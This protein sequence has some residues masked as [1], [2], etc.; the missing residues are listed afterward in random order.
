MTTG[1]MFQKRLK[2]IQITPKTSIIYGISALNEMVHLNYRL[3]TIQNFLDVM[4]MTT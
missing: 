4:Q 3:K 2:V 1:K